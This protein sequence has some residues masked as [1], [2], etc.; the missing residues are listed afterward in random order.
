MVEMAC[1]EETPRQVDA[2]KALKRDIAYGLA[3]VYLIS[4]VIAFIAFQGYAIS[5]GA[6]P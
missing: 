1:Y 4:S 3:W 2:R 5:Q 6:L